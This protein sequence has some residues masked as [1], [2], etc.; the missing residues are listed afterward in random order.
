[1]LNIELLM[2]MAHSPIRNYVVPGL[3]SW[4]ISAPSVNGAVRMFECTRNHQE[5]IT[6]HSHRFDFQCLVL[7]G[8]VRNRVWYE[9]SSG[10]G[11][12]YRETT[13]VYDG[14]V[15][16]YSKG[17]KKFS[18]YTYCE[19]TYSDGETYAMRA[20]EIHSIFFDKGTRVLFFEGPTI[21][22]MSVILEPV[23]YGETIETFKVEPWMFQK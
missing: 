7:E 16:K 21:S 20:H 22:D 1:M 9:S 3:T 14:G 23:A 15:G 5:A 12:E 4:L 11:D 10:S 13:L 19:D 17:G 6:P 2:E 18:H 8:R